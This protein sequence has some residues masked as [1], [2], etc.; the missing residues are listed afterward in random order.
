MILS[1]IDVNL[2]NDFFEYDIKSISNK[3][4]NKQHD[5][6]KLKCFYIAKETINK[7]KKHMG[8]GENNYKS[9]KIF[10]NL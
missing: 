10:P 1:Y 8:L 2:S 4:K 5:Y 6:I 3:S 7:M 9:Y